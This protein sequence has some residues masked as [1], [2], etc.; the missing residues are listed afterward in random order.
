MACMYCTAN[1]RNITI[2]LFINPLSSM[3]MIL[4]LK[5]WNEIN[6]PGLYLMDKHLFYS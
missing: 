2:S 6:T 4:I 1:K 5:I 3:D